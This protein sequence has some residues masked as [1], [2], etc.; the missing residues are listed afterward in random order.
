MAFGAIGGGHRRQ[1]RCAFQSTLPTCS[2]RALLSWQHFQSIRDITGLPA[3]CRTS[4]YGGARFDVV[5]VHGHNSRKGVDEQW[6]ARLH[7][8]FRLTDSSGKVRRT[9]TRM[10]SSRYSRLVGTQ[11][12]K[13]RRV[14]GK[15]IH[16]FFF[17]CLPRIDP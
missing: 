10:G 14:N 4:Y 1:Q 5:Q 7:S 16:S 12:T 11:A 13:L 8:M 15:R 6:W 9:R 3:H 2:W 17:S